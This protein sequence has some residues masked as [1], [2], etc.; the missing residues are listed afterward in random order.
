[1]TVAVGVLPLGVTVNV[2]VGENVAVDAYNLP[3]KIKPVTNTNT[4]TS[5]FLFILFP[6]LSDFGFFCAL[7]SK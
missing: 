1:V 4:S 7:A 3:L 6:S 5:I 2:T